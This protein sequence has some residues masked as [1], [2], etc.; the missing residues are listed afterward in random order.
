M[1]VELQGDVTNRKM[2]ICKTIRPRKPDIERT[3]PRI[4]RRLTPL[5]D[6][7]FSNCADVAGNH[8]KERCLETWAIRGR[9]PDDLESVQGF[10]QHTRTISPNG[11]RPLLVLSGRIFLK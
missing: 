11:T 6:K 9:L 7:D 2:C 3:L 1:A 5:A 10:V 8:G 4:G